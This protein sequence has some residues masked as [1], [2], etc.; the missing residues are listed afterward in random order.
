L[1]RLQT[2]AT[3]RDPREAHIFNFDPKSIDWNY[4]FHNIHI[5]GVLK[6]G[7]KK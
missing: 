1:A 6:Y 3:K 5:P 4:Y 2:I 7:Q